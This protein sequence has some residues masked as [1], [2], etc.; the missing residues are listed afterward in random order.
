MVDLPDLVGHPAFPTTMEALVASNGGTVLDAARAAL[1]RGE[2][3]AFVAAGARLMAPLLP[4][5]LRSRGAVE[6]VRKVAGPDDEV[7]WPDGGGWLDY[8]P[9]VVAVLRRQ[10]RHLGG[11]EAPDAVFGYTLVSDWTLRDASGDPTPRP[12]GLPVAIGPCIATPDEIDPQTVFVTVRV[13]GEEWVKGNLNGAARD[14]LGEVAKASRLEELLPG[15]AFAASPFAVS[16]LEH[17]IWP[18]AEIELEADGIG[19]LRTRIARPA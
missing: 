10:V 18:G 3:A 19:V 17:R 1:E 7:A 2:A 5:S 13:D 11:E 8:Q 12:E 16:G 15:D 9:K 14:L 6:G 4:T